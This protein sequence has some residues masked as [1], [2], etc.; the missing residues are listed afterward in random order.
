MSELS[1]SPVVDGNVPVTQTA[2]G[3]RPRS[4]G[5]LIAIGVAV[6]ILIILL[7]VFFL[8]GGLNLTVSEV[9]LGLGV[10][11][12]VG[13]GAY[14]IGKKYGSRIEGSIAHHASSHKHKFM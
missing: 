7:L 12:F 8:G 11:L 3:A 14:V 9:A 1:A 10:A 6:V 2:P 4:R 13:V 5:I